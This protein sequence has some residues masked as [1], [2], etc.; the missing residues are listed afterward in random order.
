MTKRQRWL[1]S[2]RSLLFMRVFVVV[3]SGVFADWRKYVKSRRLEMRS[4]AV[5]QTGNHKRKR[6][7][8]ASLRE[9]AVR[10]AHARKGCER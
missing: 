8:F 6:V 2:Q 1:R 10:F 3:L 4:S 5:A 7:A 9:E